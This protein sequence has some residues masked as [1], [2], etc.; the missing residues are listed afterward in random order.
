MTFT[1]D[2]AKFC[3]VEAPEKLDRTVRKTVIEIGNRLVFRSPVG[4]PDLWEMPAPA[5]YVG[6]RFRANWLYGFGA[7]PSRVTFDVDPSGAQTVGAIVGG[8][9]GSPV[10]GMHYIENT[11]PYAQRLED[12]YSRQAPQGMVSLTELEFPEIF[13]RASA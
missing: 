8:V 4:D 3:R 1:A 2:M 6:G 11:L 9:M 12:G 5:G 10:E 7:A 13:R